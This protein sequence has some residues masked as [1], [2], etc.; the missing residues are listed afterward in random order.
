MDR[1]WSSIAGS[2]YLPSVSG[3]FLQKF[4]KLLGQSSCVGGLQLLLGWDA[5]NHHSIGWE[6]D[7]VLEA[8]RVQIV[9]EA[10]TPADKRARSA[11]E[12]QKVPGFPSTAS[13]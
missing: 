12:Y 8:H 13:T 2:V 5:S 3:N 1:K 4:L 11:H 10:H 6:N 7:S 9:I